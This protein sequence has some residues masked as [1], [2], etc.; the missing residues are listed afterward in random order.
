ML[1]TERTIL[2]EWTDDDLEPFARLNADP[3]V[4]RWFPKTLTRA[5]SD[6]MAARIRRSLADDGW[7]LWALEVPGVSSFCGFVGLNPVRFEVHFA[8]ATE[9]GWRL[10]RPW[11][12]RGYATE[13]ARAV[14]DFS[15]GDLGLD[16]IVSMTTTGNVRSRAVMERLGMTRDPADD[17]DHPY[18]PVGSPVRPHVLY[19]LRRDAVPAAAARP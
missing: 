7:G 4:M 11:W 10:D 12:G 13:S 17:F 15:F 6:D 19:R 14:V 2:R 5:E 1:R 16:E 9:I 8:P 3:E 18:V